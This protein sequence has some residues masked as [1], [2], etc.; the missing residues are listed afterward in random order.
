MASGGVGT[1]PV[2]NVQH[3]TRHMQNAYNYY[4]AMVTNSCMS[5][6]TCFVVS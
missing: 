3:R 4:S 6:K 2:P 5:T 1:L